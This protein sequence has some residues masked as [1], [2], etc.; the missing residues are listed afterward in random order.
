MAVGK[1]P[2]PS[3]PGL[4]G[5]G[6]RRGPKDELTERVCHFDD[7]L[8]SLPYHEGCQYRLVRPNRHRG[9]NP[10]HEG[11]IIQIDGHHSGSVRRDHE[12]RQER[13]ERSQVPTAVDQGIFFTAS[14]DLTVRSGGKQYAV[15]IPVEK[16]KSRLRSTRLP[17]SGE[18]VPI[19]VKGDL[20]CLVEAA[21]QQTLVEV[22]VKEY[23]SGWTL[24]TITVPARGK[25]K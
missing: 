25:Q 16:N 11:H 9:R 15:F 2:G 1:A 7:L 13:Q 3:R 24:R 19:K 22:E 14:N 18:G 5:T 20:P 23:G 12:W 6:E 10:T 8:G 21:T 17:E 4:G